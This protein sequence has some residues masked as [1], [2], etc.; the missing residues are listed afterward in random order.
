MAW[1]RIDETNPWARAPLSLA[2][3]PRIMFDAAGSAT[4]AD[5]TE[6][7]SPPPPEP[8]DAQPARE[9][10]FIDTGVEGWEHIR[11]AIRPDVEVVLIDA[12]E[13]GAARVAEA[14]SGR[15]DL[16]AIHIFSHGFGGGLTLGSASIDAT[17]ADA[18]ADSFGAIGAALA[19]GA[20][21]LIYGCSVASDGGELIRLIAGFTNADVAA[22]TDATGAQS[23]G[24]NWILEKS[25][26]AIEA[27]SP[28][29]PDAAEGL[30]IMLAAPPNQNFDA[31]TPRLLNAAGETIA[32]VTYTFV[33][34]A[35]GPFGITSLPNFI[36][37]T[38]N[39]SDLAIMFNYVG[40]VSQPGAFEARFASASADPFRMVS[41]EIDT[42]AFLGTSSNLTI[43]GYRNGVLVASDTVD[44]SVSDAVGSITYAKNAIA[45]GRG[46][47]VTFNAQ[48][49]FIDEI[50][51]T[52]VDTIVV[53]DDLVFAAAVSPNA[54]PEVDLNGAAAGNDV[55]R[56]FVEGGGPV[57]IAPDALVTD[58]DAGDSIA[59]MTVTLTNAQA[60]DSLNLNGTF[61]TIGAGQI[62]GSGGT[63]ITISGTHSRADI[64][65]AL[66]A[67]T[68]D[69]SS[70]DPS[71]VNRS[72]AVVV[73]DG[74]TDSATRTATVTVTA[75]NDAP[76]LTATG[77][78]PTFTEDG[79]AAQLFTGVAVSTIEA[80]Q[81]I[82]AL[83]FTVANLA[84]GAAER[85]LVDGAEFQLVHGGGGAL[86]GGG[87]A[88]ISVAGGVATVTI[89]GL[90]RSAAQAQTL[91]ESI[92]YR[93]A[94]DNP[95]IATA[96]VATLTSVSDSGGTANGGADT[97]VLAISST[98]TLVAVN[99]AP[100][101]G[102]AAFALAGTNE[103]TTSGAT[104]VSAILTGLA[105]GDVD[106]PATGV[107][108]IGLTGA[109]QW[110]ASSD[111]T[112]WLP[113]GPVGANSARLLD[114][115]TFIRYV[116]DGSNGETATLTLRGWD[117]SSGGSGD[118][119]D[120]TTNGGT[121]A[122]SA[123]TATVSILVADVNDAPT[124]TD[125]ANYVFAGTDE[126]TPGAAVTVATILAGVGYGDVD[127]GALSGL[128]LI[129]AAGPGAW[130]YSTDGG[131]TWLDVGAVD[132]GAALLL[133]GTDQLRFFTNG[134]NGGT[135]TLSFRAWDQ[136][137]GA[138]GSKVAIGA[139]GGESAFSTQVAG[140][141][142]AV[143][144]VNDAPTFGETSFALAQTDEN[145]TSGATGVGAILTGL[146]F[147]DVD[148]P[149]SG[150]AI[151]G[152]AGLGTW[153]Y[154]LDGTTWLALG[155]VSGAN[156]RLLD[157]TASLRYVPN[158][159]AGETATLTVRGWDGSAGAN[160]GAADATAN[161]GAT[162]FS[163]ATATVSIL[164][165]DVNDAPTV[166][167]P[168]GLTVV[169][170][171]P[172]ALTSISFAD[173]DAGAAAVTAT[174]AATRGSLVG[175]SAGGVVVAGSGTGTV[176]LTGSIADINA[177]L[178]GGA[179]TYVTAAN[180]AAPAT[181]TVTINDGGAAGAGGALEATRD[182]AITVTPVNDAPVI[183]GVDGQSS[184]VVSGAGPQ[185]VTLF[186]GATVTDVDNADFD[187]GSLSIAQT[188]GT[189]N[190]SF[191]LGAGASSGGD[192]V[193]SDGE[194]VSVGGVV[195]GTVVAGRDG[196][197][198]AI[199]EI[200]LNADAT[201]ERVQT[202][203]RALTYDAPS[204][205]G[206]RL[207]TLTIDDGG[208]SGGP[209]NDQSTAT[210]S[211]TISATPNPPVVAGLDGDAFV[212]REGDGLVRI[213]VGQ[214]A[215]V[216]DADSANFAG[217]ELRVTI[218]AGGV[219]AEDRLSFVQS[220][221]GV[222]IDG[223]NLR[224]DG[225]VVGTLS[226]GAGGADLVVALNADATPARV[227]ALLRALAYENLDTDAPTETAR[228]ISVTIRDSAAGP[229]AATSA[230]A[231]VT[232]TVEG[233]N[234]APTLTG[235]DPAAQAI[236][237]TQTISPFAAAVVTDPDGPGV[238]LTVT[239]TIDDAAKGAFTTPAGFVAQGG[240]VYVFNGTPAE[241]QTAL[242][243]MV[244]TPA[245]NRVAPGLTETTS[246]TIVVSD[247]TETANATAQVQTTSV[248]DA[249]ALGGL[250]LG[251]ATTDAAT[252]APF[253]GATV[254]DP[255][256]GQTLTISVT[257]DDAAKGAFTA[258]SLAASGFTD[259]GGGVYSRTAADAA[260]A[261][262]ALRALVFAPTANRLAVGA[263]E[264]TTFTVSVS[265]GVAAAVVGTASVEA[266][267]VNDAPALGGVPAQ[268]QTGQDASVAPFAAIVVADPD[269][270]QPANVTVTID[271]PAAGVF[272]PAS[273][274][275]SGFTAQGGGVFT[276]GG[277]DAAEAQGALRALVFQPAAGR[278]AAGASEV[279]GFTIAV[280]D[281]IAT[282]TATTALTISGPAPAPEAA[283]APVFVPVSSGAGLGGGLGGGFGGGLGGAF[284]GGSPTG[285]LFAPTPPAAPPPP[286]FG[287]G[288]FGSGL[289]APQGAGE[290]AGA[291]FGDPG[292]F[293]A[294]AAPGTAAGFGVIA[295]T[296]IE[297]VVASGGRTFSFTLPA[298]TFVVENAGAQPVIGARLADGSPLPAWIRFD[299]ERGAFEI[300]PPPG[301]VGVLDIAL[302][303]T[304]P[305]GQF[306]QSGFTL[307]IEAGETDAPPD[308]DGQD[309]AGDET[310]PP[311][312]NGELRP[313]DGVPETALAGKPPLTEALKT[314]SR[315]AM[316]TQV[317]RML[318]LLIADL[319]VE[320]LK[321]QPEEA[322][323]DFERIG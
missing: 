235:I 66:R 70:D 303:A 30:S 85:I 177:F 5:A 144:D 26:G 34:P 207:F 223:A 275:A 125:G 65:A 211:F 128:A 305:D 78:S 67:I 75:V 252:L 53:L 312:R 231:L 103:N 237:D 117:G 225:V 98:V 146:G 31:E 313:L 218:A 150:L 123:Q 25:T 27:Q 290:S 175:A 178:G 264:T 23:L 86:P 292:F 148:G 180:D 140:A 121:T 311:Q 253:A 205:L 183:G 155:A 129:G 217:G 293:V 270:G 224:V 257:L 24:G 306:A 222:E 29:L 147:A 255:D 245:Q 19:P 17:N 273:L 173:V 161:G 260:T 89:S 39:A 149:A 164:V 232:I 284:G 114:G 308:G 162:P 79:A 286:S 109:G 271:N 204:G 157:P 37:I 116:P 46:G 229:G 100:T 71:V 160:G 214:N 199:L 145:T 301:F 99:D 110:Q 44:T 159:E 240:G 97:T 215:V 80:G 233:V 11:D 62:A 263:A 234:D 137:S 302:V 126:N 58:P 244:F 156:A 6:T 251:Q 304:L 209:N 106:G 38:P 316:A 203:L 299:P 167:A 266:T 47:T 69:N 154:S 189:A 119:A 320:D 287:A 4:Y 213:D 118:L 274:A 33:S 105:F 60:G 12:D 95:S 158:G 181:L 163:A 220:V 28:F 16:D 243:A 124:V 247:G 179:L 170:D 282:G 74:T 230:A 51:I 294:L 90:A 63:T 108:I 309:G 115:A 248:N 285:N 91:V 272:T 168:A 64:Q 276:F 191:G 281:G 202:L 120:A 171:V 43:S 289:F 300:E 239:V 13:D 188:G 136:T 169:E 36:S 277:A 267:S 317:E 61:G 254:A 152:A 50:R 210:A 269:P 283:S 190:G 9:I 259:Q 268:Q 122:F 138:A 35:G 88:S 216:T 107:A 318:N 296:P 256:V 184:G 200:T 3:E 55:T 226:G 94:S 195:I 57:A 81:T 52:G 102:E 219:A 112:N 193:F 196:Q 186:A 194:A 48:W 265:D 151:V 133:R 54:A 295:Q 132:G 134:E 82:S 319:P 261:Q 197:N 72:I 310:A 73:N 241:A 135:G 84:D 83:T 185:A 238:A 20:D 104:T 143:A 250:V 227:T 141:T 321:K 307:T 322:V 278:L 165:T 32:G 201:P 1:R 139:T 297:P 291:G 2:L 187:G 166:T 127:A 130:R 56:A 68:F 42:G 15:T 111:G 280:S 174:F 212:Y 221:G 323:P 8:Q 172:F 298:A 22:S 7:E 14:L 96:R 208:A 242:R 288:P 246:F 49:G 59:S 93:N 113:I 258:G 101:L 236:D 18:F 198:G 45:D 314:A 192:A 249:P 76:T 10:A 87:T 153:Q 228:T 131:T 77:A 176:T 41:M 92:A 279:A 182:V 206:D 262:A 40:G 315:G 142:I 21:I